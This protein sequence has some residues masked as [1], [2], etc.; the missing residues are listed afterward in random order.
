MLRMGHN[1]SQRA[2]RDAILAT[3]IW[4][5]SRCILVLTCPRCRERRELR[6][7]PLL[8]DERGAESTERFLTRLRC[9]TCG[10]VP[11]TVRMQ[12]KTGQASPAR[13]IMLVG[14]GSY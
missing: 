7:E 14:P 9:R 1:L 13:E 4:R 8:V 2:Q 3:P 5:Y 10:S 6:I 12:A 11:D